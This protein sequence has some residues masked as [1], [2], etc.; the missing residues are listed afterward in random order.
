M[1]LPHPVLSETSRV[2]L[3]RGMALGGW[4]ESAVDGA[5]GNVGN[6]RTGLRTAPRPLGGGA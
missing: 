6:L 1:I 2:Q 3:S 5:A 4:A